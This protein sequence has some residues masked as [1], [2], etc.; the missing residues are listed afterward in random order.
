LTATCSWTAAIEQSARKIS[1]TCC[2]ATQMTREAPSA[3]IM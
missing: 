1:P 2:F 3:F